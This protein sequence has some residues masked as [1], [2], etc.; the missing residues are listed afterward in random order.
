MLRKSILLGGCKP[1]PHDSTS[2]YKTMSFSATG[3]LS[4][5]VIE[6]SGQKLL[7]YSAKKVYVHGMAFT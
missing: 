6:T 3:A 4:H 7:A 1:V 2:M 5:E